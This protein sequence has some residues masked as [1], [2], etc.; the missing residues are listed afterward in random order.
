M[1]LAADN[2]SYY[3][4]GTFSGLPYMIPKR[5]GSLAAYAEGLA[6]SG[7]IT[8][9]REEAMD[10]LELGHGAF[11]DAARRLT[12]KG[13][14]F[15]P[16]RGFYVITPTR[17]LKWGAPP[18]SFYIDAM[19]KHAGIPYYIGLQ[20]AAELSGAAH[21]AVM[22]FQV[23]TNRQ[24][25]PIKAGRS[26]IVF[27]YRKDMI[28]VEQ[29]MELRKTDTGSMR[30]SSPALTALDLLRYRQAS[31][32]TDHVASILNELAPRIDVQSLVSLALS[33]ER[34]VVQRL[35]YIC[36]RLNFHDLADALEEMLANQPRQWIELDPNERASSIM[37][38]EPQRDAR[39]HIMFRRPIEIDEQ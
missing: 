11:Q 16:R 33:F 27:Y 2:E 31:G 32:S 37:E 36:D 15:A 13:Y 38:E 18:P 17:F 21:Q 35:G 9:A 28:A 25:K 10:A 20:K 4:L 22:E 39:W 3:K 1:I 34:T 29:G 23:V 24:W 5:T 6:S 30:I 14:I 7:R 8:F 26:K 12:Q 19:M